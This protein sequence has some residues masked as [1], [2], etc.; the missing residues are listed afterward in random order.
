MR[1]PQASWKAAV[2][3]LTAVAGIALGAVGYRAPRLQ[4]SLPGAVAASP[5]GTGAAT[6]AAAAAATPSPATASATAS[7]KQGTTP[8]GST[9][10][11]AT[12]PS[13][14][15]A[16]GSGGSGATAS[17]A[18]HAGAPATGSAAA[19][20]GGASAT[21]SASSQAAAAAGPLLA[22]TRYAPYAYQ[23][24]PGTPSAAASRA[25]SG[26]QV[27]FKDLGDGQ[28]QITITTVDGQTQTAHFSAADRLYFIETRMG[29]DGFGQDNDFGDDGFILTDAGGHIVG[30]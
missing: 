16:A 26:F 8:S 20:G 13:A 27:S 29:D 19:Q 21:G 24:Y 23:I 15:A 28:E 11:P 6:A 5:A 12:T 14:S 25:L 3:V 4:T 1:N 30:G 9:D 10:H 17:A 22:S 7:A 2:M 18:G